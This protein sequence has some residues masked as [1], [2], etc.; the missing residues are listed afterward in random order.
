MANRATL[1]FDAVALDRS[2]ATP[3]HRQLY[4]LLRAYILKGKLSAGS[5]LPATRSLAAALQVGRN[6]VIA[7]YEQLLIEGY[8][9]A[10][11]G[12]GT[13]VAEILRQ[14]PAVT[15]PDAHGAPS[16]F[17]RR[18][19]TIRDQPQFGRRPH[20]IKIREAAIASFGWIAVS[21]LF[22]LGMFYFRGPQ[23][24]LNLRARNL[25]SFTDLAEGVDEP[26]EI[27][28]QLGDAVVVHRS[29]FG[30]AAVSAHVRC[31]DS[32]SGLGD[33]AELVSP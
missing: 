20:K 25:I 7:A 10:R 18:G 27:P 12:S 4:E 16:K 23:G 2:L 13:W 33:G 31:S 15:E 8:L 9:E 19:A 29:R 1:L 6:T 24:K 17:S 11:S 21:V 14:S 5:R 26:D 3:M 28:D 32:V 22:G 30:A